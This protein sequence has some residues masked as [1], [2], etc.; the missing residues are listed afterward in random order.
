M[1]AKKTIEYYKSNAEED[2]MT[3]PISVLRYIS[4]LEQYAKQSKQ[5]E[6]ND[7]PHLGYKTALVPDGISNY[8][9]QERVDE[10]GERV[11]EAAARYATENSGGQDGDYTHIAEHFDAGAYWALNTLQDN[12]LREAAEKVVYE[13]H[14]SV[15][16]E[17]IDAAMV[18]LVKALNQNKDE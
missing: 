15:G 18:E 9:P 17:C 11:D 3:T 13:W 14:N 1:N 4:E 8:Q 12:K 5:D 10:F 2:Y 16:E 6:V 7:N